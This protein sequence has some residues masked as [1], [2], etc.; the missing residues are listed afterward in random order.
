MQKNTTVSQGCTANSCYPCHD[1]H[2]QTHEQ[3]KF[4][5]CGRLHTFKHSYPIIGSESSNF[6][7]GMQCAQ[8]IAHLVAANLLWLMVGRSTDDGWLSSVVQQ[9]GSCIRHSLSISQYQVSL[10][11]DTLSES[12]IL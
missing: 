11:Q 3:A 4:L 1:L 12:P 10:H 6:V 8:T 7:N 5:S 9:P 2:T